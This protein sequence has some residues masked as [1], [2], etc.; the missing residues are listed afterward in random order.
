MLFTFFIQLLDSLKQ[1]SGRHTC[2]VIATALHA[3]LVEYKILHKIFVITDNGSNFVQAFRVFGETLQ[4]DR[5]FVANSIADVLDSGSNND[6]SQIYLPQHTRCAAHT[7]NLVASVDAK[8]AGNNV[9]YSEMVRTVFVKLRT[10]WSKQ[11]LSVQAAEATKTAL[12]RQLPV[13]NATRWNSLFNVVKFIN[14][15]PK[16][17]VDA[18]FDAL[19]FL[20]TIATRG[21]SF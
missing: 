12:G 19:S 21:I 9:A 3:V 13:P 10:L 16:G 5:D 1:L 14:E 8:N 7:L 17:R 4:H 18:T 11:A 15:I 20:A 2:D 6:S